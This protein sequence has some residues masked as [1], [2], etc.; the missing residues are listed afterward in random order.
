MPCVFRQ[1]FQVNG[2][3]AQIGGIDIWHC[4]VG[5]Y[6]CVGMRVSMSYICTLLGV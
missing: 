2:I 1:C 4:I 6:L 3:K 5:I